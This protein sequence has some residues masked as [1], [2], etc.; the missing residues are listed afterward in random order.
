MSPA[1]FIQGRHEVLET[2]SVLNDDS[3]S[4]RILPPHPRLI[5]EDRPYLPT[6]MA[7]EGN[8]ESIRGVVGEIF[9]LSPNNIDHLQ[10]Q[11]VPGGGTNKIYYVSG[12]IPNN[13]EVP[14]NDE[15]QI[16]PFPS[17][18]KNVLVRLF[19]APGLID[20]DVETS[21]L[22]TLGRQGIAL[23]Y[24]GRFGNGRLEEWLPNVHTLQVSEIPMNVEAIA[25]QLGRLHSMFIIPDGLKEYH[26]P[27]APPTLWTQ[28][29]SW[30]KLGVAATYSNP[31]DHDR[32]KA[33]PLSQLNDEMI[34]L[35]QYVCPKDS[36]IGF[37]HNDLLAANILCYFDNE[38]DPP[39]RKIQLIDFEFSGMNYLAYDIANHFNEFA[40]GTDTGTPN[41]TLFPSLEVQKEFCQ[42]YLE[43]TKG[44][45][46]SEQDVE[47]L[48]TEVQGFVLA[49]HL[50]WALWAVNQASDVGCEEF[51]YLLY[52]SCRLERY[53]EEKKRWPC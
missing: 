25:Q 42:I 24:Y 4:E 23:N 35:Q 26:N 13:D 43:T 18:P 9:N 33:L 16:P 37:C 47:D 53:F 17:P 51:D 19:G 11:S 14:T 41:Y 36:K 50:V 21:T 27:T 30:I 40:G 20:R 38:T 34:W 52:A 44:R 10:V 48:L 28:L 1:D 5:V 46:H 15:E 8:L 29:K 7:I 32:A 12:I 49:N 6:L 39:Q 31:H 3:S 22:A 2:S 45:D